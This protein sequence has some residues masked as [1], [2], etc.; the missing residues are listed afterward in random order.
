MKNTILSF[1]VV[2]CVGLA[3]LGAELERRL[4][5]EGDEL[6]QTKQQLQALQ[7]EL[8]EKTEAIENAKE[9]NAKTK[10]LQ[11]TLNES[12]TA[13]AEQSRKTEQLQQS[14]AEVKT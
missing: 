10:T 5:R 14:L 6:A 11:Q 8:Q 7:A 3:I 13:V 12:T 2:V 4:K 1:L 9:A